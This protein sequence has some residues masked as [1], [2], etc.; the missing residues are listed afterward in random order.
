MW[1]SRRDLVGAS[2]QRCVA[3]HLAVVDHRG[4]VG[5]EPADVREQL[6]QRAGDDDIP[7]DCGA[8]DRRADPDVVRLGPVPRNR[9]SGLNLVR[10]RIRSDQRRCRLDIPAG[11]EGVCEEAGV[12]DGGGAELE[13]HVDQ[14]VDRQHQ[15]RAADQQ[16]AAQRR[17]HPA[18]IYPQRPRSERLGIQRSAS[19]RRQDRKSQQKLLVVLP[20]ERR[21][22]G[23]H[24]HAEHAVAEVEHRP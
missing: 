16:H 2:G 24:A 4:E 18:Y 10:V 19:W 5:I 7:R 22:Q 6:R 15:Q 9:Q 11:A 21:G 23:Q 8:E 20:R 3:S 13:R 12:G 14:L 17:A 1:L